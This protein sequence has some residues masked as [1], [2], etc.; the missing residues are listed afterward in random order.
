[1]RNWRLMAIDGFELD[2]HDT[3]STP[4]RSGTPQARGRATTASRQIRTFALRA[5]LHKNAVG[6]PAECVARLRQGVL[7]AFQTSSHGHCLAHSKVATG[8]LVTEPGG[9][10]IS[11]RSQTSNP[12]RR[13]NPI[14]SPWVM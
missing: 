7:R 9:G 8:C 12:Q 3:R 4:P 6:L 13:S 1:L 14:M 11:M 2:V 5:P 10:W